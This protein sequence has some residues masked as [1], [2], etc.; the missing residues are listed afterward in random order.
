M[1]WTFDSIG[2]EINSAVDL[3]L[4]KLKRVMHLGS[5]AVH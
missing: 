3:E 4:S 1:I 5:K 2:G